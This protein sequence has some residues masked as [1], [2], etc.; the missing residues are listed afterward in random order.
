MHVCRAF[1]V[2]LPVA[3]NDVFT[4]YNARNEEV[5]SISGDAILRMIRRELEGA[6]LTAFIRSEMERPKGAPPVPE[7][8]ALAKAFITPERRAELRAQRR[9]RRRP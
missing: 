8:K 6:E 9:S 5:A 1:G 3:P 4:L 2:R 7:R